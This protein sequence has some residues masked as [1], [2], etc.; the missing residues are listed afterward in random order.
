MNNN[1]LVIIMKFSRW[2]GRKLDVW[3]QTLITKT[4]GAE[5]V[6]AVGRACAIVA[7]EIELLAGVAAEIGVHIGVDCWCRRGAGDLDGVD[8]AALV[9][10]AKCFALAG[11]PAYI[12]APLEYTARCTLCSYLFRCI[13]LRSE[14]SIVVIVLCITIDSGA[15]ESLPLIVAQALVAVHTELGA[16]LASFKWSL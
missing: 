8:L 1:R 6:F 14:S 12:A 11:A 2:L 16:G 5:D 4:Q 7:L 10:G 13:S 3:I 15:G 9:V